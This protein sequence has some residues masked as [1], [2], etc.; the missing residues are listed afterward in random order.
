MTGGQ[1]L[2][3]FGYISPRFSADRSRAVPTWNYVA[4]HCTGKANIIEGDAADRILRALVAQMEPD[5]GWKLEE[6]D[7]Q[8]WT[9]LRAGIVMFNV[10]VEKT[11]AKFKLSQHGSD[12]DKTV[13]L[14]YLNESA[15]EQNRELAGL[16]ERAE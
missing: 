11:E 7:P 1:N 15:S 6:M 4:V 2:R 5:G 13:L 3:A 10:Q 16:M 9:R 14:R 8:T 12:G